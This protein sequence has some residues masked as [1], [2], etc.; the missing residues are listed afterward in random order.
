MK[1]KKKIYKIKVRSELFL[2]YA[3]KKK[4]KKKILTVNLLESIM[5][6]NMVSLAKEDFSCELLDYI[7][8]HRKWFFSSVILLYFIKSFIF[9]ST[10][11]IPSQTYDVLGN[12]KKNFKK[13]KN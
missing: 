13:I 7:V 8:T 4:K 5:V 1:E 10:F 12:N 3:T 2:E 9:L 6:R 11:C